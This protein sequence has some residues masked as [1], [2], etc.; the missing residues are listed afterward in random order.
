VKEHEGRHLP[1][2]RIL[3]HVHW[4]L[5]YVSSSEHKGQYWKNKM[6]KTAAVL[7]PIYVKRLGVRR[8]ASCVPKQL[9]SFLEAKKGISS[10]VNRASRN[11]VNQGNLEGGHRKEPLMSL[12]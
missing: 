9:K 3:R 11:A 7:F 5:N 1:S 2:S 4:L 10:F 8:Q 6:F 12:K